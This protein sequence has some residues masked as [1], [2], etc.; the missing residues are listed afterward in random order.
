MRSAG[1][2]FSPFQ[3]LDWIKWRREISE[4]AGP[5]HAEEEN[6]IVL[7][8]ILQV[9]DSLQTNRQTL[10]NEQNPTDRFAET[11][12]APSQLS[13]PS[14]PWGLYLSPDLRDAIRQMH[15]AREERQD[16]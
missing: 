7:N 16:L 13:T 10:F 6:D 12:L 11:S 14:K 9:D 2:G 1:E 3:S 15:L 5:P 4:D 8:N